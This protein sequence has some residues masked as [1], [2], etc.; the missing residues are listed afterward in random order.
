MDTVSKHRLEALN[1]VMLEGSSPR[2]DPRGSHNVFKDDLPSPSRA[3]G[4]SSH[5]ARPSDCAPTPSSTRPAAGREASIFG[6]GPHAAGP[7]T[8]SGHSTF[9]SGAQSPLARGSSGVPQGVL[10]QAGHEQ[11]SPARYSHLKPAPIQVP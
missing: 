3:S 4:L 8:P 7:M 6:A 5:L 2:K 10:Q 1:K 11:A 9:F